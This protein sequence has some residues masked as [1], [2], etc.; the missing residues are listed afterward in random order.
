MGSAGLG[1]A[2][3]CS[4]CL[5]I[6]RADFF[7]HGDTVDV[8]DPEVGYTCGVQFTVKQV[9]EAV[10]GEVVASS[11]LGHP[12]VPKT[13]SSG[14]RASDSP[15]SA[16][17]RH[18]TTPKTASATTQAA[19]AFVDS[20]SI[21]SRAIEA[22]SLFVPIVA[23][24]DGHDFIAGAVASGATSF[25][26]DKAHFDAGLLDSLDDLPATAI[27][28]AD[29]QQALTALGAAAR[30][31]LPEPVIGVTGSV[32]KTS[33]KDLI[34]AACGAGAPTHANRASFNNELGLPLTLVNAPDD[35]Q[36]TVLEMGS[37]GPGH[38]AELCAIGRP[39]IGLVT[40]VAEAHT[41]LFG[42]LDGVAAAKGELIEALPADG[43][44]VLNADDPRVLAMASRTPCRVV[45][46]GSEQGDFRVADLEIDALVR[47]RFVL[48]TPFGR[49]PIRLSVSGAHMAVNAAGA[50]AVAVAAGIDLD[51]A[52]SGIESATISGARMEV[53]MLGNGLLLVNDAYNANP[54]S[55]RAAL[56]AL[57][58]LAVENRV[59]VVGEMAELGSEGEAQ[60]AAI[61]AEA[62]GAGIRVIAVA[63]PAYGEAAEHVPD[64][65]RALRLATEWPEGSAVLV[66]GSLVAGL[67][68]FA[69]RLSEE[70][71]QVDGQGSTES[72]AARL[73]DQSEGKT[74]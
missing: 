67:Q 64:V 5:G 29:T 54:T 3:L 23:E 4:A 57:R 13:A 34:A 39:T 37:R 53:T 47:P 70:Y 7:A 15:E 33:V 66:K 42:S 63:A 49:R 65:E 28:V 14:T 22:G 32:G 72:R 11:A 59:A 25:F 24:R 60:H 40:R 56:A 73:L 69:A 62:V 55:M 50:L 10:V 68:K 27:V 20:V 16:G 8:N 48:E 71:G 21:D 38:I 45:T 35:T 51:V 43:M 26:V 44:A 36:I 1:S 30:N 74:V 41:E 9:V 2:G 46:F 31:R 12:T 52:I 58:S 17:L 6:A 18:P 19:A 61:A